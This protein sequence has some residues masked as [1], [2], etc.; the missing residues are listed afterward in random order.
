MAVRELDITGRITSVP[1]VYIAKDYMYNKQQD[2]VNCGFHCCLI[3]Q[4]YLLN[5]KNAFIQDLDISR[6]RHRI[7]RVLYSL[8]P[9]EDSAD[10]YELFEDF[11]G[12][13][14]DAAQASIDAQRKRLEREKETPKQRVQRHHIDALR[15]RAN[16]ESETPEQ[17]TRRLRESTMRMR[18]TRVF[19]SPQRKR[20]RQ[21]G[22]VRRHQL[23]TENNANATRH[24]AAIFDD[25]LE[26][27]KLSAMNIPCL[28]CGAL[29]FD[30]E[31]TTKN[32]NSFNDCCR[33]GKVIL[34]RIPDPPPILKSLLE[35]KHAKSSHFFE[36]I[37]RIN[38]SL[39]F[40]SLNPLPQR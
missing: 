8:L 30:E 37:R 33:H 35:G 26:V 36:N 22:E 40:A 21:E 34:E 2:G 32:S 38:S 31:R 20:S 14:I 13:R 24:S 25:N 9:D 17:N 15:A 12:N 6:E 10:G 4:Y 23:R 3:T 1:R 29:H 5:G 28:H 19:E 7:I 39:S 18:V 16:R 11:D 27:H